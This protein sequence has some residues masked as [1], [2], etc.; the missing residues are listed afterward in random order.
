MNENKIA[1]WYSNNTVEWIDILKANGFFFEKTSA[2]NAQSPLE[3][4]LHI[5]DNI[6][7]VY[8][9]GINSGLFY[10]LAGDTSA[11]GLRFLYHGTESD[12]LSGKQLELQADDFLLWNTEQSFRY[13][14]LQP[15]TAV[16][17]LIPQAIAHI[18][19]PNYEK[20]LANHL[21]FKPGLGRL[22][23]SQLLSYEAEM[24]HISAD[25]NRMIFH[26]LLEL[27]YFWLQQNG[28]DT[29][30]NNTDVLVEQIKQFTIDNLLNPDFT[31][32][33]I[34]ESFNVSKR[35]IQYLFE[36]RG[37]TLQKWA[38]KQ[39]LDACK[40][41]LLYSDLSITDIALKWNFSD[42]AHF[43]RSFKKQNNVSPKQFRAMYK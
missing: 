16:C 33:N 38:M 28:A 9:R 40:S 10:S 29:T 7:I 3:T 17:L 2:V 30:Q 12:T 15:V 26:K 37:T 23:Q 39:K 36:K 18:F 43:S 22:V 20:V 21:H 35:Y 31:L 24:P 41:E 5:L 6:I 27:F 14:Q 32:D 11:L 8:Q 4:R 42:S 1:H 19:M 34:A 13:E 25:D